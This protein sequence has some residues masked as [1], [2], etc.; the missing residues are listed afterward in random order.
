MIESTWTT[1][2]YSCD[3]Q[4]REHAHGSRV[5]IHMCACQPVVIQPKKDSVT[6]VALMI[7][8]GCV[9]DFCL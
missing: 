7:E 4:F 8:D 3:E 6:L 1:T 5:E 2:A 9:F